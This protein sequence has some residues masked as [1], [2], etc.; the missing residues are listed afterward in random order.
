MKKPPK[1]KL[2]PRERRHAKQVALLQR[3]YKKHKQACKIIA[4]AEVIIPKLEK[5]LQ[6]YD[7]M[8]AMSPVRPLEIADSPVPA[9][10]VDRH[11][12]PAAASQPITASDPGEMPKFLK[13]DQA[14]K[15]VAPD[16][17]WLRDQADGRIKP[18]KKRRTADDFA[19]EMRSRKRQKAAAE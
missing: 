11:D 5:Q 10:H 12:A 18:K 17:D 15:P 9:G 14:P 1:P 3:W 19:A 7:Q 8:M 4:K 16:I 6:R 2:T 13:R